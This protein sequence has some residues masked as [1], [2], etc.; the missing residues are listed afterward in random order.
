VVEGVAGAEEWI[1]VPVGEDAGRWATRGHSRKVLFVVHNVT[2]AT[3]LLDVLPLFHD[4]FRVQL[5]VTCTESSAFRAG[6]PSCWR[7]RGCRC[8][9]GS[10][11]CEHRSIWRCQRASAVN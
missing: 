5:L 3:R 10:R 1:R 6:S 11:P 8:C 9:P 2:S 4:D 7:K